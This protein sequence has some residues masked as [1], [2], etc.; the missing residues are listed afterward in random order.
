VRFRGLHVV[1]LAALALA[2]VPALAS[3]APTGRAHPVLPK[4]KLAPV[5]TFARPIYVTAP[6]N[7]PTRLFVVERRGV[8]R[9]IHNGHRLG[10]AFLNFASRVDSTGEERGTLSMA[11]S[12]DYKRTGRFYIAF[13][14][15]NGAVTV[16]EYRRST[17]D[18]NVADP[19]TKRTILV[20]EHPNRNHNS[21]QLQFGKDGLLYI[22]IGDG[23]GSGDR[24]NHA[25]TLGSR[26]GKILRVNPRPGMD[27]IPSGNPFVHTTGAAPE[28][29]AYGFR[30]PWRFSFDLV[31]G[32]LAIA[33]VGQDEVE[34][35]DYARRG[36][37][38]GKNYGWHL[39]EGNQAFPPVGRPRQPCAAKGTV[40]PEITHRHADGY[41]AAIGGYVVRDRSLGAYYGR[42]LYGDWCHGGML[43]ARLGVPAR[44]RDDR[45]TGL[46][47]VATTAFGQDAGGCLY[48]M[49]L[50]GEVDR[51]EAA[52]VRDRDDRRRVQKGYGR[53]KCA[54]LPRK[55]ITA[56]QAG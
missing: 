9:V 12:P 48:A 32:A 49:S 56:T 30:N 46:T 19:T 50:V 34:E 44:L 25:Q 2:C 40:A 38:A 41:C 21:G 33:D 35:I 5:G 8:I 6:P 24:S 47:L 7:D 52:P 54:R 1:L 45:P 11:F 39:C 3:A 42:Y 26:F 16:E 22:G 15:K 23:G 29:Y 20:Q 37:A 13:N 28:V 17:T 51:I 14:A 36:Q 43:T 4:L 10:K 18:P 31:S 53:V 27:F 55:P